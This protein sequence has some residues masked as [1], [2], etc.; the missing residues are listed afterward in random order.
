MKEIRVLPTT[1]HTLTLIFLHGF[2]M[3]AADMAEEMA[4]LFVEFP[5]V[6]FVFPQ[7]PTIAISAYS[8]EESPAWYDYFTDHGGA[9]EDNPGG[10]SLREMRA[11]LLRIVWREKR[12]GVPVVLGGLSQGGC[13]ALDV[14]TRTDVLKAVV[15]CVAHRLFASRARVLLC[16]WWALSAEVDETFPASWAY[17]APGEAAVHEIAL[18]SDHYLSGGEGP[19]FLSRALRVF[20]GGPP[21]P[22]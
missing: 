15:T 14:A 22:P 3:E 21:S 1:G 4:G 17:P 16:P 20:L 6:R 7:A 11:A 10:R 9:Q 19:A 8:G 12:K 5:Q 18:R 13:I 2:G